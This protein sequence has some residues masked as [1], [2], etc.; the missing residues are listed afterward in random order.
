MVTDVIGIPF[1]QVRLMFGKMRTAITVAQTSHI[2]FSVNFSFRS[3]CLNGYVYTEIFTMTE[4]R[5]CSRCRCTIELKH[6][7]L[8]RKGEHNK[9]C[10]GCLA[11]TRE[12]QRTPEAKS[13]RQAW[14]TLTVVCDK[15]GNHVQKN[16][17][18]IHERRWWCQTNNLNPKPEF[19]NW[20]TEQ[21]YETLLWE[22]KSLFSEILQRTQ[23][24]NDIK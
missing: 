19:E 23:T 14:D 3:K 7:S 4:L 6:Y 22:Y 10:D 24:L 16:V 1:Q 12:Y 21:D 17:L 9:T 15:C 11:K 18:S 5:K 8:N 20:L 13:K 2:K